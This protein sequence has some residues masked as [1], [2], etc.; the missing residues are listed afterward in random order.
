M[1]QGRGEPGKAQQLHPDASSGG[2]DRIREFHLP[3]IDTVSRDAPATLGG[4]ED[5]YRIG[6]LAGQGEY[7]GALPPRGDRRLNVLRLVRGVPRGRKR[8]RRLCV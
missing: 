4:R 8:K 3:V 2:P 7:L 6:G 5:P 1:K